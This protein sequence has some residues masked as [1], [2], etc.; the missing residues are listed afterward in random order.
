[1]EC[2]YLINRQP[3]FGQQLNVV[4]YEVR[5]C[6]IVEKG[7]DSGSAD[8][9]RVLFTMFTETMLDDIVGN[10]DCFMNLTAS[11]LA[12]NLWKLVPQERVVLGFF[13][14][15]EPSSVVANGLVSC[16][17]HGYRFALSS[18]L[19]PASLEFI[20][21]RAYAIRIDATAH[22]PEEI[23]RRVQELRRYN[24]KLLAVNVDTYDDLEFCKSL[25]FDFYAGRFVSRSGSHMREIPVNRL[26]M[27]RVLAKLQQPDMEMSELD[28]I[29]S[30][31]VSLTF[32]LLR[33]ANSAAVGLPRKVSSTGHAVRLIGMDMLRNWTRILL[34]SAVEDRPRELMT[35]ALVRARMCERLSAS[36]KDAPKDSF[37]SAGLLSVLDALLDCPMEKALAELPL[38][39]E[40][41]EALIHK[42]GQIGQ[43]LRCTI[44]YE[45]ADWDEVQFYGLP[46]LPIRDIYMEAISWAKQVTSGLLS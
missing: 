42:A 26:A 46:Q 12:A 9:E 2:N 33:Y 27:L 14:P 21:N 40:V 45:R 23:E 15:F 34:L 1:M 20:G 25:S 43:A 39:D 35:I 37:F 29:I 41:R 30:Q 7:S 4:G 8:A 10:H 17:A 36:L 38:V 32:K 24:A 44:A 19:S 13:D 18:A 31:D 6:P 16:V 3:V 22:P 11:G 28:K 5:T